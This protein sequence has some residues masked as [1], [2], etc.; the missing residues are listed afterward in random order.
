MKRLP[1]LRFLHLRTKLSVLY[2]ALFAIGLLVLG[3]TAQLMI[4]AHVRDA[5]RAELATSGVV[6]DRI[7]ALR[8]ESLIASADVLARDYGFRAAVASGDQP[9][10]A[11]ALVNLRRRAGVTRAFV[12]DLDGAVT[13]TPGALADA[14]AAAPFALDETRRDAV[15]V[16]EGVLYR[17]VLS[18]VLAPTPMGWV[19]FAVRLD[20]AEMRALEKLSAIPLIAT[21]LHRDAQGRWIAS[22]GSLPPGDALDAL[23]AS[24]G[25]TRSLAKLETRQGT[26]FALVRPL[27]GIAARPEAAILVRYPLVAAMAP[28]RPLQTGMAIA[29]LV[30][31]LLMIAGSRRLAR[32]I[33]GPIAALDAAARS[34]EEGARSEV[35]VTGG[36]EIGR[37][38]ASFNRM[39]AGIVERENRISHL[40]F[41]DPLTGLPNRVYFRQALDQA[42]ARVERSGGSVAVLCLDLDRFK[43][44]NDTLGHPVGDA[45]LAAIGAMLSDLAPDAMVSRLGGDEYALI[46]SGA[47]D[48]DR[49]RAL[50]QAILDGVRDPIAAGG[51]QIATGVSVGIAI[52]P[53]DGATGDLLLKN[54]DLALYRGKQDGRGVFRFFEPHWTP[55]HAVAGSWSSTCARRSAA[56]SS[57]STTSRCSI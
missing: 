19:V 36:D 25:S 14:V 30:G 37:L 20:A 29:G 18:P 49:P 16:V 53:I 28:Y 45:L 56:V 39:S 47:F 7:W 52:G 34:L 2:A 31:L 24:A 46:L 43:G 11:S 1:R 57:S 21:M 15:I 9:T 27:A 54:A 35:A 33:A 51:H 50:A 10:I 41:H 40:A 32:S 5:V 3:G 17:L 22:D 55:P 44:V 38:A 6:Y 42:L 8:A 26:A 12:V 23:V 48:V 4:G 13:G